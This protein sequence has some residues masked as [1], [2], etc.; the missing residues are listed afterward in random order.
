MADGVWATMPQLELLYLHYTRLETFP[1][2][3]A[4]TQLRLLHLQGNFLTK[5]QISDVSSL[6][7]NTRLENVYLNYN[8]LTTLP[9]LLEVAADI[10]SVAV[11]FYVKGNSLECDVNMC[12]MKY[13][14]LQ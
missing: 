11:R 12:W 3:T 6:K 10:S 8:R 2:I 9:N 1:N 13:L 4:F 14:S 5:I 7:Q